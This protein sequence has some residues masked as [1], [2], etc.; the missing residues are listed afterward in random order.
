[1]AN[2]DKATPRFSF[3]SAGS[4]TRTNLRRRMSPTVM[5]ASFSSMNG[6]EKRS[7]TLQQGDRVQFHCQCRLESG[8]LLLELLAP[9]G[10]TS[11]RW[12]NTPSETI[13]FTAP[14]AGKYAVRVTADHARGGYRLEV[15]AE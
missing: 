12:G 7:M 2:P 5:E 8:S 1:M 6:W 15:G 10:T 4:G 3:G 13:Q 14:V 9:D 11:L